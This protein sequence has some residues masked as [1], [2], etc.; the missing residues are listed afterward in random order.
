MGRVAANGSGLKCVWGDSEV[1]YGPN[2]CVIIYS[3]CIALQFDIVSPVNLRLKQN[4][5]STNSG[6]MVKAGTSKGQQCID[7]ERTLMIHVQ[8]TLQKNFSRS[9]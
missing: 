8:A 5:T 1:R 4:R 7:F 2:L 3:G 6:R 9:N